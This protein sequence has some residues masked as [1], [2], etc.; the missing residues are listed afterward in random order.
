MYENG[1]GMSRSYTEAVQ[2]YGMAAEQGYAMAQN[3]LGKM[4][5]DGHGV[6]KDYIQ[7]YK[8]MLLAGVNGHYN[9]QAIKFLE[10]NMTAKQVAEGR[11]MAN[12]YLE[13]KKQKE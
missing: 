3:N 6:D 13:Q 8:W 4:Y 9:D 1:H 12:E 5:H 11:R 10:A 2:W 7:A